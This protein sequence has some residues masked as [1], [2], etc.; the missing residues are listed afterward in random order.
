M[1]LFVNVIKSCEA[2]MASHKIWWHT[3]FSTCCL[4]LN[5]CWIF[6]RYIINNY[7]FYLISTSL[8]KRER[9][10]IKCINTPVIYDTWN[11]KCNLLHQWNSGSRSRSCGAFSLA[12]PVSQIL[13]PPPHCHRFLSGPWS[14]D[15]WHPC[16]E[17]D[18]EVSPW[19]SKS[20]QWHTE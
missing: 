2:R 6:L 8:Y 12:G 9:N 13:P 5:W 17:L 15:P 16:S 10:A 18:V 14:A 11:I 1:N 7:N 3:I 4:F 19:Y 20:F